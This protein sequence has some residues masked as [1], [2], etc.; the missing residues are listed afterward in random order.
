LLF[1]E[2]KELLR[3]ELRAQKHDDLL[4]QFQEKLAT[5]ANVTIYDSVLTTAYNEWTTPK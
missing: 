5:E 3:E 4:H 2:I 1:D